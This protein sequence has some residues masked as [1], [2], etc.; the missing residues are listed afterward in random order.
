M[1]LLPQGVKTKVLFFDRKPAG[2]DTLDREALAGGYLDVR[3]A[4]AKSARRRIVPVKT[5]LAA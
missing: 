4:K 3:A 1:R 5:E 2:G